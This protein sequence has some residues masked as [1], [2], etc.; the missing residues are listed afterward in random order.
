MANERVLIV[1]DNDLL[2]EG[3]RE[4]LTYEGF[5]V[6]TARNGSEAIQRMNTLLPEVIV[7]DISMPLMDGYEFYNQVRSRPEWLTIP[8]LFLT[9]RSEPS[10]FQESR[11]LGVDDYLIKPI[12]REE[13]VTVIRSRLDRSRQVQVAQVQ[14]AYQASLSTLANAIES[15]NPLLTSHVE[16]L[17]D[18]ALALAKEMGWRERDL[19]SLCFGAILHDIGK[20]HISEST[21]FKKEYLSDAEWAEIHRHPITGAEMIKGIP[22]LAGVVLIVRHHH[23]RWD[24][25]GY[26][27]GLTGKTIPEGARI[28]AVADVFDTM[29]TPHPYGPTRDPGEAY[30]E[31]CRLSG[32]NFDP[33]VVGALQRIWESGELQAIVDK[34]S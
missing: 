2:R 25:Q 12:T 30:Q 13:L 17:T 16:R 6:E 8:F 7:S 22:F 15:R 9:A 24:G 33:K 29:T 32:L 3:L 14:Q 21:L 19:A 28:L 26:P 18:L 34:Y 10:D 1:E 5:N 20:I 31:I 27:D 4:M 11:H 23:E